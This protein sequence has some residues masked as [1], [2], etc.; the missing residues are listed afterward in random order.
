MTVF[1]NRLGVARAHQTRFALRAAFISAMTMEWRT[2]PPEPRHI[3]SGASDG[4]RRGC[5]GS[6]RD[7]LRRRVG[8]HGYNSRKTHPKNEPG[9]VPAPFLTQA[10]WNGRG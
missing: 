5:R 7:G 6:L 2:I 1:S 8:T 9:S 3:A 10:R 4:Y